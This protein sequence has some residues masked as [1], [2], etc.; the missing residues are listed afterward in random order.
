MVL[1]IA[2]HLL[3]LEDKHIVLEEEKKLKKS[4][5]VCSLR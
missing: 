5:I 4:Q 3:V 2:L 1:Q